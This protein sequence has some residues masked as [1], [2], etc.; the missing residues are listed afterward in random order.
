MHILTASAGVPMPMLTARLSARSVARS[1]LILVAVCA[2]VGSLVALAAPA[3]A[4]TVVRYVALGDSYSSGVGAG[5]YISSSGS[6]DRS[7]KAYSEL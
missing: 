7:T 4:Q 5:S 2:P 6:C 3:S 1:A